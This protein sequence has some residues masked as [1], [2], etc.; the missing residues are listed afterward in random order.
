[1]Y[2]TRRGI[3]IKRKCC[4]LRGGCRDGLCVFGGRYDEEEGLAGLVK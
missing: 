2:Y 3:M 4:S 1:M